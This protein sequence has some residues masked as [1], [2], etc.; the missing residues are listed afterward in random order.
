MVSFGGPS[1]VVVSTCI[2]MAVVHCEGLTVMLITALGVVCCG[3]ARRG[4]GWQG[5]V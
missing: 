2:L 4:V 1:Q 3:M 5:V